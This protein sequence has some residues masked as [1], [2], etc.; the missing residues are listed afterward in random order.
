V[1]D[2]TE[3]LPSD[4]SLAPL[5]PRLRELGAAAA[6]GIRGK[7]GMD[8]I[9]LLGPRRSER[10]YGGPEE[11]AIR[12]VADHLSVAIENARL[13]TQLQDG[14]IYNDILVDSLV[15][16]VIAANRDRV[17]TT[18]N[19]EAQRITGMPAEAMLHRP[20]SV[21]P[22]PLAQAF[23]RTFETGGGI[24][25]RDLTIAT[26]P[27]DPVPIQL[28]SSVFHGH[29]GDLL[30]ALL[31]FSDL[32]LVRKLET[33]VR[34]T[35]HLASLGTLSAGMAH[36]IKNPLVTLKAFAQL[37][38]ESYDDP[39]FRAAFTDLVGKEVNRIDAIV[40]QLL[41][42]GRPAKP[43]LQPTSAHR[44]LDQSL[45]LV[46]LPLK[47]KQI[48]LETR[49]AAS[50]DVVHGDPNLLEQAFVNFFLNAIDSMGMGGQL[51]VSTESLAPS[52]IVSQW[53][54]ALRSPHMRITISDTGCG[55]REEDLVRIF[56]PF[57]TTKES[58]AGLGLSIVHGIIQEHHGLIDVESHLGRGT[59][60]H[61]VLPLDPHAQ[62]VGSLVS[63]NER[64]KPGVSNAP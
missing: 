5:G 55:I 9:I 41:K 15:S 34:R 10:V 43:V 58:G 4:H 63:D 39:E 29:K 59:S 48:G 57:F 25:N 11:E 56:D 45:Q 21:L 33:Q 16:G 62:A 36:E 32:S 53:E 24:R 8:G 12:S 30:G 23:D 27:N 64:P 2:V 19:R 47:K 52:A 40:N 61:I 17:I 28:G 13:Y 49:W 26:G 22:Q 51:S 18:V 54:A 31:V 14:K 3:R 42:F 6:V 35:A 50:P 60:F 38:R 37:L 1:A 20:V 46:S 7:E 44:V